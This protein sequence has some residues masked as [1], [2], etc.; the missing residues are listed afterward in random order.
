MQTVSDR[1]YITLIKLVY[2]QNNIKINILAYCVKKII[3]IIS[4]YDC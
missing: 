2:E 1:H 4:Y 3:S